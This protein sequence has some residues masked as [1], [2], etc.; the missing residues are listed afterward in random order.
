MQAEGAA[1]SKGVEMNVLNP[2]APLKEMDLDDIEARKDRY[3]NTKFLLGQSRNPF[4]ASLLKELP[5]IAALQRE[6]ERV[7]RDS[8]R[9]TSSTGAFGPEE[10]TPDTVL[11]VLVGS[12]EYQILRLKRIIELHMGEQRMIGGKWKKFG[13]LL[14]APSWAKPLQPPAERLL[15]EMRTHPC[16]APFFEPLAL[17]E[18]EIQIQIAAR[19]HCRTFPCQR[20]RQLSLEKGGANLGSG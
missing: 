3:L 15:L 16:T 4:P 11:G 14:D 10:R 2:E 18:E 9:G 8:G 6:G 13:G 12:V 17:T 1:R 19:G 7:A 20:R 5:S